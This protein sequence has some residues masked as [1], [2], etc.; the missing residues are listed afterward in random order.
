M[1]RSAQKDIDALLVILVSDV[2]RVALL[3]TEGTWEF[4][5]ARPAGRSGP[6][7]SGHRRVCFAKPL[8]E[9]R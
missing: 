9:C 6:G 2:L 8:K 1:V 5:R 4:N 3:W 7:E